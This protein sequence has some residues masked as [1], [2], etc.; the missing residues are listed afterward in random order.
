MILC[1]RFIP[2]LLVVTTALAD[3]AQFQANLP[4]CAVKCVAAGAKEHGCAVTDFD[5]QC[6]HLEAIIQTTSPCLVKAGCELGDLS[7]TAN[8]VADLCAEQISN[9]TVSQTTTAVGATATLGAAAHLP[10]N[11]AWAGSVAAMAMAVA[12][13]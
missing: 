4:K 5:C 12:V 10:R 13:L 9:I 1:L 3:L 6:S 7:D 8:L 2:L 11:I